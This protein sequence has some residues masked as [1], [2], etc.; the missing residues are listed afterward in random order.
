MN[1]SFLGVHFIGA[2]FAV[3][4]AQSRHSRTRKGQ[5]H[6]REDER[7][8]WVFTPHLGQQT[9]TAANYEPRCEKK[10]QRAEAYDGGRKLGQIT[11]AVT[12]FVLQAS[13]EMIDVGGSDV[14]GHAVF[15]ERGAIASHGI[16][17]KLH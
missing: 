13:S 9:R 1:R 3:A 6:E 5:C 14:E 12:H 15:Q 16:A 2:R 11:P 10:L 7:A 4:G 17:A 8:R